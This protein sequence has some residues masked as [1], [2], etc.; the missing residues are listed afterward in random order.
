MDLFKFYSN[1]VI[2]MFWNPPVAAGIT[3]DGIAGGG[4]AAPI[5][6]DAPP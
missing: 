1:L 6:A 2:V 3:L 4:A 5:I